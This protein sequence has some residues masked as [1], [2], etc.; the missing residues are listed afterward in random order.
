MMNIHSV[1][2]SSL[3]RALVLFLL[4]A[5][6][7]NNSNG[8]AFAKESGEA[9][10]HHAMLEEYLWAAVGATPSSSS[11]FL[12]DYYYYYYQ[13]KDDVTSR[14]NP[15]LTRHRSLRK[16]AK[17]GGKG[18]KTT[19]G[20]KS[21]KSCRGTDLDEFPQWRAEVGYWIGEYTLLQGNGQYTQSPSW[22]YP[23]DAYKGFITGNIQ[24]GAYR[25]RNVFFYPPQTA[26]RCAEIQTT[27]DALV[28]AGQPTLPL[29]FGPGAGVCGTNGNS[30][31]FSAD[32]S[33]CSNDGSI[34]GS[35]PFP[36]G[37]TVDTTTQ[38]VGADNALLYQVFIDGFMT[39]S[40]LTTIHGME[41][42]MRT[43]TAQNF[44]FGTSA[45]AGTSY[46]RE[47]KVTKEEFYAALQQTILDYNILEADV[48]TKDGFAGRAEIYD[49]PGLATCMLHLE[50]SF[51]L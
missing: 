44:Q 9:A 45:P 28:A 10:N 1:A 21:G 46:Y 27:N 5:S 4:A 25:Q 43:R 38:L 34:A 17:S 3:T 13:N 39:Q 16:G 8:C 47:R 23:Y 50:Q 20:G 30:L 49:T 32:Q 41:N 6:C 36:G 42:N 7:N 48:C 12:F 18:S 33:G 2:S 22:P 51:E 29:V 31:V 11:S 35:F 14:R 15:S 24:G 37:F 19:K 26:E 40:Q